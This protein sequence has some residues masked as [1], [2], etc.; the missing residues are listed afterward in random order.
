M[1]AIPQLLVM[2]T[3]QKRLR[4]LLAGHHELG[5][6]ALA[7]ILAS[8]FEATYVSEQNPTAGRG[9]TLQ[10]VGDKFGIAPVDDFGEK[11]LEVA[12]RT[13]RPDIL[14]SC[15]YRRIITERVLGS[16]NYP[17]NVHFGALPCYRGCW[18]IPQAIL[19]GDPQ[20]GVTLHRMTPGIDDGPIYGYTMI[21]DDGTLSCKDLYLQAVQAG[22]ELILKFLDQV[23]IGSI[24]APIPQN[25][26]NATY[27]GLR[28]PNDFRIDWRGTALQ[29]ARYIRASYFPP[30]LPA[31]SELDSVQKIFVHW[32]VRTILSQHNIATGTIVQLP[33]DGCGV[34][35]LNGYI[36]PGLI[37]LDGHKVMPF[38][39][40]AIDRNW[41]GCRLE[42]GK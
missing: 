5:S 26:A 19:N 36:L 29:V 2:G 10:S 25:E 16:V 15:G 22:V 18:S 34:A 9:E 14:L 28:Y 40:L 11:P 7:A 31:N 20:I 32:P 6:N 35:V 24:P 8:G 27:F 1:A 21:E 38:S 13:Y 12:V 37:N 39:E 23:S 33:G 42:F 3:N 17:I 4:L 30:Y 41:I